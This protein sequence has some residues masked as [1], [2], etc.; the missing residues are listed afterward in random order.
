[1]AKRLAR[2][3]PTDTPI[4]ALAEALARD[5]YVIVERLAVDG[6]RHLRE[7]L[8]PH[9][10]AAPFGHTEFL[11]ARTKRVGSVFRRAPA[12]QALAIHPTIMALADRV[13]LPHCARYQ[14]NFSGIM[15]LEPGAGAQALHRDGVLYPFLHPCPATVMPAMWAVTDFTTENGATLVVPE[16]HLWEHDREPEP[17]EIAA[18]AMP[19]G[20]ALVYTGGMLHG[21]GANVSNT[22]RTGLALQYS[23]GWL[24]QEENQYLANPPEVARGYPERLQR[25]IGYDYGGPYLGFVNG[26]DPNRVL[27]EGPAG[28]ADRT[29]PE[30]D[31]AAARVAWLRLGDIEPVPTPA[32]RHTTVAMKQRT[33]GE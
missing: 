31:A 14:L 7:E 18:A 22:V 10:A 8:A 17:D 28:P 24:R 2:R 12:T 32:R 27:V 21:G 16:S 6:I 19:A 20:S 3:M 23:L 25:L 13:L 33:P 9:I 5:G 30:L 29:T 1:M 11:G 4:D 26:G 15:H